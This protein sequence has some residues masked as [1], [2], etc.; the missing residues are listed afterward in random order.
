MHFIW[1]KHE[2]K[3]N[4]LPNNV[5]L[6]ILLHWIAKERSELSKIVM[7]SSSEKTT[8]GT[9]LIV[10]QCFQRK[11]VGIWNQSKHLTF[12]EGLRAIRKKKPECTKCPNSPSSLYLMVTSSLLCSLPRKTRCIISTS[13][14]YVMSSL[15]IG[16]RLM[17]S[18][19][20]ALIISF[21]LRSSWPFM[22]PSDL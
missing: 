2:Q 21:P 10:H 3:F 14:S 18:P 11:C 15:W 9:R 12:E 20:W 6:S 16:M 5:S 8:H 17:S 7:R 4:V 13:S 22:L 1:K 19:S